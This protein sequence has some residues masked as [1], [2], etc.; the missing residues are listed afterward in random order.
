MTTKTLK[1]PLE[2]EGQ[3]SEHAEGTVYVAFTN[4]GRPIKVWRASPAN[5]PRYQYFCHGLTL[6]TYRRYKYS[7]F[8]G[9][10]VLKV[11]QDEFTC[12]GNNLNDVQQGDVISWQDPR[13]GVVHTSLIINCAGT[14]RALDNIY[15]WTKNGFQQ[16]KTTV[17]SEVQQTY[18]FPILFWRP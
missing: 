5:E 14:P 11:L 18:P 12:I 3:I 16:E 6:G 7:V 10:D 15:V 2:Q 8:S 9:D 13:K 1:T 4:R 17:L